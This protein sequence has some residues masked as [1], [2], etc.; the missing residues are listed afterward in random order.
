MGDQKFPRKKYST[1]R[2]PWEK[3]RID[4][5][6]EVVVSYGLKN[7]H[8]LWKSQSMLESFRAQART[9]QAKLRYQD[10]GANRQ[11]RNM[12]G[13]LNRYNILGTEATLD[14]VLSL[15]IEN[16]LDR[17]LQ[18]LVFRKNLART[19]KQARQLITHGHISIDGRRV[20]LPGLLVEGGVE[21]TII[22]HE[23]S[24]LTDELHPLRQ[25]VEQM[26]KEE[27]EEEPQEEK[28]REERPPRAEK[29]REEVKEKPKEGTT[30]NKGE[31]K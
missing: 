2:H 9:L 17:R 16:I 4:Q 6:R 27:A 7:K 31:G 25:I 19:Q 10:P 14:D 18:T 5:E 22:Y 3:D 30:E 26:G 13:R 23:N 1:P 8:E 28:P 15:R 20:N 21:E 12:I 29:K 11:F 24:P